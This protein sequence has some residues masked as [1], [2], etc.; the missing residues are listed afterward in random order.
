MLK[1]KRKEGV[2]Y[3]YNSTFKAKKYTLKK[4]PLN[5]VSKKSASL[6][7]KARKI[8]L[9]NYGHQCFLC[10]ATDCEIHIHHW[11]ETR[12]QNPARK[13]DQTNLIPL[14]SSCHNHQGADEKFYELRNLI[15]KKKGK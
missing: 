1:P 14:C 7:A 15:Q 5:K 13:Y 4:S 8:C 6:W 10:G 11:Q 3:F 12:T 2:V 9:D